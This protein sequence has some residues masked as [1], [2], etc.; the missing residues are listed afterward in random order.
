MKVN[1]VIVLGA[2]LHAKVLFEHLDT[3]FHVAGILDDSMVKQGAEVLQHKVIGTIDQI[4]SICK[5]PNNVTHFLV[6][7]GNLRYL[8]EREKVYKRACDIGIQ[9]ISVIASTAYISPSCTLGQG[10]FVAPHSVVHSNSK[11]GANVVMYSSVVIEHDNIVG[12]HV[13]FS[14]RVT[15]AG[16]VEIGDHAYLGPGCIIASGIK[17][18]AGSI[19]GAGSVVTQD[20]PAGVVAFGAPATVRCSVQEYRAKKGWR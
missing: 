8:S 1:N 18:G 6:G 3:S 9:P 11:I 15:T 20:I 10:A 14:P 16:Q 4:E 5:P 19:I 13:F 12:D 2:G 7:I 17:I